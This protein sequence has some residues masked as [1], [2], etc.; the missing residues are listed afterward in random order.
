MSATLTLSGVE[1]AAVLNHLQIQHGRLPS[2]SEDSLMLQVLRLRISG[3]RTVALD[4]LEA[5]VI[6]R[7]LRKQ[8]AVLLADM[9]AL[10]ERRLRGGFNGHIENAH[11]ALDAD[12]TCLDDVIRRLWDIVV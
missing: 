8:S 10:E 2:N 7:Y 11:R 5:V 1:Q 3:D 12:R 9:M 4:S 6:L